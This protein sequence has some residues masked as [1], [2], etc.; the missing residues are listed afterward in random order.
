MFNSLLNASGVDSLILDIFIILGV[1]VA[2]ALIVYFL[3]E[4]VASIANK[5]K[6][7]DLGTPNI[8]DKSEEKVKEDSATQNFSLESVNLDKPAEEKVKLDD[9]DQDK[10]E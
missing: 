8:E 5:N 3:W 4:A 10:A 7:E 9:V 1:V 2:G 6:S